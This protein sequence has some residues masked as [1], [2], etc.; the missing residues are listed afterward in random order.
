MERN[1][2]LGE[3]VTEILKYYNVKTPLRQER[4][5]SLGTEQNPED[6]SKIVFSEEVLRLRIYH[7][8]DSGNNFS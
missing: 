8:D 1:C 6:S 7:T 2:L 3:T 5:K 4:R